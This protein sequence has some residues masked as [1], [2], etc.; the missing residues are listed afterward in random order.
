[1]SLMLMLFEVLGIYLVLALVS[2]YVVWRF[3]G[4]QGFDGLQDT[5]S[6]LAKLFKQH[7]PVVAPPK[8]LPKLPIPS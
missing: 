7:T 2:M 5:D 4:R 3:I 6:P 8:P 1:M